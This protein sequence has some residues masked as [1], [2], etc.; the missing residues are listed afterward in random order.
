M[1][2]TTLVVL[3]AFGALLAAVLLMERKTDHDGKPSLKIPGFLEDPETAA[4]TTTDLKDPGFD[5]V[6]LE[7]KGVKVVLVKE[8]GQD[9]ETWKMTEPRDSRVEQFKVK[10]M[11]LPLQTPTESLF[12]KDVKAEDLPI[13]GLGEDE[14]TRV[15]L[16]KGG[17]VFASFVVGAAEKSEDPEAGPDEVD[18]WVMDESGHV[19]RMGGKDLHMPYAVELSDLRDKKLFSFEK[20]DLRRLTLRDGD[21]AIVLVNKA[22]AQ[23]PPKAEEGAPAPPPNA[24]D[25]E[26]VFE[27]PA[28]KVLGSPSQL[29]GTL[30]GLRVASYTT[31]EAAK[32]GGLAEGDR[33][34]AIE[35]QLADGQTITLLLGKEDGANTWAT[36]KGSDE[37]FTISKYTAEQLKKTVDDLREKK[38]LG[39]KADAIAGV[40]FHGGN[41]EITR[42]GDQWQA[43]SPP[44]IALG[45][46]E[47][48]T[49]LRDLEGFAVSDFVAPVPTAAETGLDPATAR[50][51]TIRTAGGDVVLL[52]GNEADNKVWV[53]REG[54]QEAWRATTYAAKKLERTP[55]ELR[56]KQVFG[57]PRDAIAKIALQ[58][59][60]GGQ[61]AV[62]ERDP[63]EADATKAWKLVVPLGTEGDP[64]KVGQLV[65]TLVN[66]KAKAF[67]ADKKRDEAGLVPDK[68]FRV[69]VT[70]NDGTT[71][72][73]LV[74]E[75]VYQGDNYAVVADGT[76]WRRETFTINQYQAKNLTK[77]PDDL[78]K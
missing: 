19:F 7:R 62:L 73:L 3:L 33:P 43:V 1:K 58:R 70:L 10:Q 37:A 60:S 30:A 23:E 66:L 11:L 75:E 38:V 42:V 47:V 6:V 71:Q 39:V 78:K 46:D 25:G 51:V 63:A 77:T 49:L 15:E 44:G 41:L 21:S 9:G 8:T 53:M 12:A 50:K 36:L 56:D 26:W 64:S 65:T 69:Q 24:S 61:E 67:M 54:A 68:A 20:G 13:Y 14:R 28:D 74:S 57:F 29:L 59:G 4:K 2:K 72:T 34:Y 35:A 32:N 18:T 45:T 52:I 16:H 40:V 55:D 76:G 27:Q 22:P 17:A 5:K 48:N 31:L